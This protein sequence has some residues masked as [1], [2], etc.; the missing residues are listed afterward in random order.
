[1]SITVSDQL[2]DLVSRIDTALLTVNPAALHGAAGILLDS[3]RAGRTVFI[4]GNG[5][6]AGLANHAACDLGIAGLRAVSLSASS[7]V[8]T[9]AGNDHGYENMFAV[10][11]RRLA[12]DGDVLM[13]I[14]SSGKSPNI[15]AALD[16]AQALGVR[17][18]TLTGFPGSSVHEK[19]DAPIHIEAQPGDYA[20][21]ET[22]HQAI[23]HALADYVRVKWSAKS[24]AA[25]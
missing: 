12:R 16:Q 21:V 20:V 8:V 23:L 25:G 22:A 24:E 10:Q 9:Q 18:I 2:R 4:C 11:L 17:T 5:G 6:S 14:S 19:A 1:M 7:E 13:A 3:K 15:I